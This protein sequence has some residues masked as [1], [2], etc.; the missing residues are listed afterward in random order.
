MPKTK[1]AKALST[2]NT[3]TRKRRREWFLVILIIGVR[4]NTNVTRTSMYAD[5]MTSLNEHSRDV[6]RDS[7]LT[8]IVEYW[9]ANDASSLDIIEFK[10]LDLMIQYLFR[11]YETAYLAHDAGIYGEDEWERMQRNA[12]VQFNRARMQD[13]RILNTLEVILT[14]RFFLFLS[15]SC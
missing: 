14:N 13:E 11:V 7:E 1:P 4:E 6:Y 8:A 3:E 9:V 10:R 15:E 5:H 12:C 2:S